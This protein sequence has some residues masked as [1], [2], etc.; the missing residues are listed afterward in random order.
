MCYAV[1]KLDK[2]WGSWLERATNIY[3]HTPL[4]IFDKITNLLQ[5][6]HFDN[7]TW[8]Q[9]Y[10]LFE[11]SRNH[12]ELSGYKILTRWWE[13]RMEV[14]FACKTYFTIIFILYKFWCILNYPDAIINIMTPHH[15]CKN[16]HIITITTNS[17]RF[18]IFEVC[19]KYFITK[20]KKGKFKTL[21]KSW[22]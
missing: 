20:R 8:I 17:L 7:I 2:C 12:R 9:N 13:L 19:R 22:L 16:I 6:S 11:A 14:T 4:M 10:I 18:T 5:M 21:S 3:L 15:I 1:S